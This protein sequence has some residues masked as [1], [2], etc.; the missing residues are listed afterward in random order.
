MNDIFVDNRKKSRKQLSSK[1]RYTVLRRDSFK[2]QYCGATSDSTKLHVDHIIPY[3]KG[4]SNDI[5]NLI[6]SCMKCNLGKSNTEIIDSNSQYPKT[7]ISQHPTIQAM[8]G[9]DPELLKFFTPVE[10]AVIETCIEIV[11]R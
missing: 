6:T 8:A 1:V 4:G 10:R 5:S 2:C 9:T 11:N 3:S 7:D